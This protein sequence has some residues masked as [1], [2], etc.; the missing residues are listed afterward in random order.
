MR[1]ILDAEQFTATRQHTIS[2]DDGDISH[3]DLLID[4]RATPLG[5]NDAVVLMMLIMVC[6]SVFSRGVIAV[7]TE[8]G[9][10]SSGME[11]TAGGRTWALQGGRD[12]YIKHV[13]N[14]LLPSTSSIGCVNSPSHKKK[15]L[16]RG[17]RCHVMLLIRLR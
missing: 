13:V 5:M 10:S 4:E 6:R 15:R 2:I 3:V 17:G 12:T 8:N 1:C 7:T 16:P 14:F 11:G 9:R